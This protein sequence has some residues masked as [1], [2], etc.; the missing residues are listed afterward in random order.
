MNKL[1]VNHLVHQNP[2]LKDSYTLLGQKPFLLDSL[3][4]PS[5]LMFSLLVMKSN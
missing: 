3:A 2:G 1:S 4:R 5:G